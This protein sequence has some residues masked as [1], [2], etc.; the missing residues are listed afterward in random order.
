MKPKRTVRRN[1]LLAREFFLELYL[2]AQNFCL[3]HCGLPA[4]SCKRGNGF[5][6]SDKR[7]AEFQVIFDG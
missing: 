5:G 7:D 6:L 3:N 4:L 1:V 2:T